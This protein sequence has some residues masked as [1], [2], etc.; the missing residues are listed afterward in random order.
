MIGIGALVVA[1][2]AAH[3]PATESFDWDAPASC[4]DAAAVVGDA[5][6]L[7]GLSWSDAPSLQVEGTV[8]PR[9]DGWSLRIRIA[10]PS[11]AQVRELSG[12]SCDELAGVAATLIAVAL[13]APMAEA[14]K[15]EAEAAEP[16]PE[17]PAPALPEAEAAEPDPEQSPT[18][19]AVFGPAV[20]LGL[21]A[22]PGPAAVLSLTA[23]AE[24]PGFRVE[25]EADL[26]LPRDGVLPSGSAAGTMQLWSVGARACGVPRT[27][28]VRFPLCGGL[29]AGQMQGRGQGISNPRRAALPWLA[30]EVDAGVR[31]R[32][33]PVLALRADVGAV[34]PL[35]RP[36]FTFEGQG[37]LHRASAVGGQVGLGLE[38]ALP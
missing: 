10:T 22:L 18:W 34:V 16:D 24:R 7:S 4:P 29:Q 33:H 23:G 28:R 32:V 37:T 27:G 30:L 12:N 13:E 11:G 36:G 35:L 19:R 26:W 20:S 1:L 8:R 5:E 38:V 25:A 31:V 21:G 2:A 9:E 17:P 3:G 6:A 14:P 15:P